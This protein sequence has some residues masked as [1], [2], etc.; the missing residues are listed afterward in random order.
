MWSVHAIITVGAA[1][2]WRGK[3]PRVPAARHR[4]GAGAEAHKRGEA[5]IAGGRRYPPNRPAT[6]GGG[7]HD[8]QGGRTRLAVFAHAFGNPEKMCHMNR[9]QHTFVHVSGNFCVLKSGGW[10]DDARSAHAHTYC[11]YVNLGQVRSGGQCTGMAVVML[12][13]TS[14]L[15]RYQEEWTQVRIL[16]HT[17]H[18]QVPLCERRRNTR[19]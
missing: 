5:S 4:G 2:R 14:G 7:R 18:T 15:R 8:V 19:R 11:V 1:H 10:S 3:V 16:S 9:S 13:S 6:A 17:Q 12:P